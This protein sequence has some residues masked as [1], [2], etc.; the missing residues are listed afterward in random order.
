MKKSI[1]SVFVLHSLRYASLLHALGKVM[2]VLILI[3][4]SNYYIHGVF[5]HILTY[6][7]EQSPS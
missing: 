6:S 2:L 7:M 5:L 4:S 3:C 1:I